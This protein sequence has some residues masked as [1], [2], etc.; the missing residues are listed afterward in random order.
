M[1]NVKHS[2]RVVS[3][4]TGLSSHAIRVWEKRYGAVTPT[5]T[6]TNRR[7]YSEEEIERLD[8]LHRATKC[9]HNI[10]SVVHLS[11]DQLRGLAVQNPAPA[12]TAS[13]AEPASATP[14][15]LV[16]QCLAAIR[17]LDSQALEQA[18]ESGAVRLGQQGLLQKVVAPLTE[19]IGTLWRQGDLTAAHEHM[20][21]WII[22]LFLGRSIKAYALNGIAPV[23]IVATPAGQ[24]HEVGAVMVAAAAADCGWKVNYLGASLPAA[25]I[26]GVAIQSAARAVAL[27]LVYPEDDPN[28]AVELQNLR[29]YLPSSVAIL[30]G[31]RAS[32]AY[33][34]LLQSVGALVCRSLEDL[35]AN[36]D[37]LRQPRL[38]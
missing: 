20:A 3:R 30:A 1:S 19:Q 33:R 22:R 28:L 6:S 23:L 26:A 37:R 25:E 8:L 38:Y 16:E 11:T 31:G 21:T 7:L 29:R 5:R 9:G 2:I 12:A 34:D 35:Y 27:S 17:R 14:E 13:P 36:L 18:F 24:L 32:P 10:G 15:S 4:R